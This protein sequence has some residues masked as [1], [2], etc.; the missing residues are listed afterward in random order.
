T[1]N[2]CIRGGGFTVVQGRKIAF[3][4]HDVWLTPALET[5]AHENDT[6]DLQV[7]LAYSNAALLEKLNVHFVDE[8]PPEEPVVPPVE[9][10]AKRGT[11]PVADVFPLGEDGPLLMS[12]ER[13]INPDVVEQSALHWSW[14]QV[15]AEL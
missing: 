8:N 9:A 11:H 3:D 14:P 15:K 10:E 4:R 7:R 6:D 12:Y 2:F 13:L 1:V 5:Y